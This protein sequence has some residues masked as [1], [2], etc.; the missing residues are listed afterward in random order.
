MIRFIELHNYMC[1]D[2]LYLELDPGVTVITGPNN[3]GKSAIVSALHTLC[4]NERG[5]YMVRHGAKSCSVRLGTEEGDEI[6]WCRKGNSVTYTING[7]EYGR[8]QG[9]VPE[10][11]HQLLRLPQVEAEGELFDLHFGLQKEPLFLLNQSGSKAALFFGATTDAG[12]LLE[13]QQLHR[14]RVASKE[15]EETQIVSAIKN[16]DQLLDSLEPLEALEGDYKTLK[17]EEKELLASGKLESQLAKL[18]PKL[19]RIS[20]ERTVLDATERHLQT[21]QKPQEQKGERELSQTILDLKR[22]ASRK[23]YLLP[24]ADQYAALPPLPMLEEE[25]GLSSIISR[26]TGQEAEL[27]LNQ[28]RAEAYYQIDLPP[29]E[30]ETDQLERCITTLKEAEEMRERAA[31]LV[32]LA[33]TDLQNTHLEITKW[34]KAHPNCPLCR[35]EVSI[36]ALTGESVL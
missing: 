26:L 5:D 17:A 4:Y 1:H 3:C 14:K 34:S 33:S 31:L 9:A 32:K 25:E 23:R 2:R 19:A 30:G 12:K 8:L 20:R 13:M 10:R 36:E 28:E 6:T 22:L 27:T 21:L 18:L 7:D 35:Q 16:Y 15:R 24:Q 11:L 29:Q